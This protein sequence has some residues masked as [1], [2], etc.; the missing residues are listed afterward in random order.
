MRTRRSRLGAC[1]AAAVACA[2]PPS[3]RAA[4]LGPMSQVVSVVGLEADL[5]NDQAAKTL[6]NALRQHVIDSDK[7]T[8]GGVSPPLVA[9]ASEVKCT[10]KGLRRPLTEASDLAFDTPCLKRLADK[11]GVKRYFW[12]Y[13][14]S[15]RGRAFVRL[16]FWQEDEPDH[17]I[18]L[19]YE[20]DLREI[21]AERLFRKLAIPE[22]AGDLTL[23]SSGPVIGGLYVDGR[24]RGPFVPSSELTLLAG[25]HTIE[26]RSGRTSLASVTL[27]VEARRRRVVVLE[28]P[29]RLPAAEGPAAPVL[30]TPNDLAS[31][32]KARETWGWVALGVGAASFGAGLLVNARV[33]VLDDRFTSDPALVAYRQGAPPGQDVCDAAN[34]GAA[35]P[36]PGAAT[37][38]RVDRLCS[39][40]ST[41]GVLRTVLYG[42]GALGV[43]A[44][45]ALLVTARAGGQKRAATPASTSWQLLPQLGS[46][47]GT[48][49]LVA[50]F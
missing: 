8:L 12:G 27:T 3:A 37:Q 13:L 21:V 22:K 33:N 24:D 49:K 16:H 14:Y 44:G 19:A 41:L 23:L 50:S 39:G 36:W 18:T 43:G 25:E 7:Y 20:P 2:L 32:S 5:V 31:T 45:A 10:L 15:E 1:V 28:P 11:L 38:G 46:G 34:A 26:V 9:V 6:T 48:L 4:P 35:P 17:A 29:R 30:P 47:G 42:V 40:A